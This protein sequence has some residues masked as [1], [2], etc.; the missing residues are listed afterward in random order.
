[1]AYNFIGQG[2]RLLLQLLIAWL[3]LCL[4]S[5]L[6]TLLWVNLQ[7]ECGIN[8]LKALLLQDYS[9]HRLSKHWLFLLEQCQVL[10][11]QLQQ[12]LAHLS[13][14]QPYPKLQH[15]LK[16]ECYTMQLTAQWLCIR[17]AYL[18]LL[19]TLLSFLASVSIV[20]GL[21]QRYI[22]R[23]NATR[24]S[25]VIY[26][27]AKTICLSLTV[28]IMM[29]VLLAPLPIS[30]LFYPLLGIIFIILILLQVVAKQFKKY[31]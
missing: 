7:G 12:W 2:I 6:I 26:H 31:L 28:I 11:A 22:R 20:D 21:A 27:Q 15:S 13:F 19:M 18:S 16:N 10:G 30:I 3:A 24:E 17:T 23:V 8:H 5:F 4:A 25:A 14:W 29:L 1:M 9:A